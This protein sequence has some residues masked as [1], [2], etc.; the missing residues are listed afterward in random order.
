MDLRSANA[1]L[2]HR[3]PLLYRGL[4]LPKRLLRRLLGRSDD[5]SYWEKRK[6]LKYY[7]QVIRLAEKY[8]PAGGQVIDVG[9]H[10][11]HLLGQL[12]WFARR[13]ALDL[14]TI[15]PRPG[16]ET[17][18]MTDFLQYQPGTHFDLV[19]C[20]QVLEHLRNPGIFAQKLLRTGRTVIISVPYKWPEHVSRNHIQD[21]VDD[22]KL[23]SWTRRQPIETRIVTNGMQRL[24]AVYQS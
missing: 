23:E 13:V 12:H 4:R 11:T 22:A 15:P 24:I 19:L 2:K 10:E 14:Y 3:F 1:F 18:E 20:L 6:H 8:V 16:I 7:Q 5:R 21:P 17:I 9:S